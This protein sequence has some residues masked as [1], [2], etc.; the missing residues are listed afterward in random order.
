MIIKKAFPPNI[1]EIKKA[2]PIRDNTVFTYGNTM[3][4]QSNHPPSEN[5]IV[6]EEVHVKQ[7]GDDPAE[8]W[9]KYIADPDFRLQQEIQAYKAQWKFYNRTSKDKNKFLF[10]NR[11]AQD[12]S[13]SLYGNIISYGEAIKRIKH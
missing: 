4:V 8:W 11:I 9:R 7:Q 13:G 12:L 1:E 2:F 10:L 5:L 6:H 3:Y